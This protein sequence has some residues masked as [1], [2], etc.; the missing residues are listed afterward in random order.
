MI[1]YLF[2][3]KNLKI[4]NNLYKNL[5]FNEFHLLN[6]LSFFLFNS[7]SV[8]LIDYFDQLLLQFF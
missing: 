6:S 4:L 1:L 5:I 8:T 2:N 7:I 3:L